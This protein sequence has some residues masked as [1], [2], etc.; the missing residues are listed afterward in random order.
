MPRDVALSAVSVHIEAAQRARQDRQLAD[1]ERRYR[2]LIA[3]TP[4]A[5]EPRIALGVLLLNRGQA[6]EALRM[7]APAAAA[8]PRLFEAQYNLGLALADCGRADEAIAAYRAAVDIDPDSVPAL[9]NLGLALKTK[10]CLDEAVAYLE[11]AAALA[12]DIAALQLNL[13]AALHDAQRLAPALAAVR[14]STELEPRDPQALLLRAHI[15]QRLGDFVAA[16]ASLRRVVAL[17]PEHIVARALWSVLLQQVGK[18]DEARRLLDY[19]RLLGIRRLDGVTGWPSLSAFND[20]LAGQ[21]LRHP[22]LAYEPPD[23]STFRGSQ[24]REIFDNPT[25]ALAALH[26]KVHAVLHDYML[27]LRGGPPAGDGWHLDA[28]AVVLNS[29]GYQAPHVH[30]ASLVSGVYY[31]RVPEAVKTALAGEAGFIRFGDPGTSMPHGRAIEGLHTAAVRPE[32]GMFVLFP[33]YL[34]HSTVPFESDEPRIC[35][36]FDVVPGLRA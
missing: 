26:A 32:E 6:D 15:E 34:W 30:P 10:R 7:L 33:A 17:V 35:V 22:T 36:A 20:A 31:V 16:E 23:K 8:A 9:A 18:T 3:A 12:P 27:R 13:A 21:I 14:R 2:E 25:G 24:T 19:L 28:W 5:P 11:R 4:D 1:A 29:H